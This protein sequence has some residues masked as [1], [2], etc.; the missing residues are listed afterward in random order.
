M[1]VSDAIWERLRRKQQLRTVVSANWYTDPT[2]PRSWSTDWSK[3]ERT[4][5][6]V[7]STREGVLK[8]DMLF[9][10]NWKLPGVVRPL[11]YIRGTDGLYFLFAAGGMY[12]FYADGELRVHE[13]STEFGSEKEFVDYVVSVGDA[14]HLPDVDVPHEPGTDFS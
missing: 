5:F 11:A 14:S 12:Y 3:W 13:A 1:P 7:D 4:R 10:H 2:L 8:I 6:W 9:K